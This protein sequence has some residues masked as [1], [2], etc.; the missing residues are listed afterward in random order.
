MWQLLQRPVVPF[1]MSGPTEVKLA[2]KLACAHSAPWTRGALDGPTCEWHALQS[3]AVTLMSA[4][5]I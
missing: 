1:I 2:W 4:W 5:L 3:R